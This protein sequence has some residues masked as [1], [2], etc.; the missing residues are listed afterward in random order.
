MSVS[1]QPETLESRITDLTVMLTPPVD[2]MLLS[3]ICRR[4]LRIVEAER[5]VLFGSHA[6]GSPTQDSD[7]DVL[8]VTKSDHRHRLATD[9]YGALYPRLVSIDIVVR[10]PMQIAAAF[11][12]DGFDP[13]LRE[14][15]RKGKVLHERIGFNATLADPGGS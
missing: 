3:E 15:W 13:F 1:P 11:T 10:T 4:I 5:I 12:D 2:E 9:I 7:I 8:V 14:V 6:Y